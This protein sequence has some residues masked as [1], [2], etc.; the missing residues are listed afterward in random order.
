MSFDLESEA[1]LGF[2]GPRGSVTSGGPGSRFSLASRPRP[3]VSP[4]SF[5][6]VE[7][8]DEQFDDLPELS[9]SVSSRTS[10]RPSRRQSARVA[11][12]ASRDVESR[13]RVYSRAATHV[14]T[15]SRVSVGNDE[16]QRSAVYPLHAVTPGDDVSP[17]DSVSLV[18]AAL[19]RGDHEFISEQRSSRASKPAVAL[20]RELAATTDKLPPQ[21][22]RRLSTSS[23]YRQV[24]PGRSEPSNAALSSSQHTVPSWTGDTPVSTRGGSTVVPPMPSLSPVHL[25]DGSVRTRRPN[26]S[27]ARSNASSLSFAGS[28]ATR[29]SRIIVDKGVLADMASVAVSEDI[30]IR[31]IGGKNVIVLE[32]GGSFEVV[33]TNGDPVEPVHF[34]SRRQARAL[35]LSPVTPR[36][37]HD[38]LKR[39]SGG[40]LSLVKQGG[41]YRVVSSKS[42]SGGKPRRAL[43]M[44][45]TPRW[46][47][48]FTPL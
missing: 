17:Y 45:D 26:T 37:L 4:F 29:S 15:S 12:E 10:S 41:D 31:V 28:S 7:A 43:E 23:E 20:A 6:H 42:S 48:M 40:D 16:R 21:A 47:R 33:D 30:N 35:G 1:S 44:R 38:R 24:P 39:S 8:A 9:Q 34:D 14:R 18:G 3:V 27:S 5:D 46:K 36:D 32:D 13:P 19:K 22:R 11:V 25:P 2:T